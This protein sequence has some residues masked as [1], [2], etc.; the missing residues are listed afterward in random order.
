MTIAT[1][2]P[3]SHLAA[4]RSFIERVRRTRS[5]PSQQ[6]FQQALDSLQALESTINQ[7]QKGPAA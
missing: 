6:E 3:S 2:P 7:Q 5:I 4:L 1:L